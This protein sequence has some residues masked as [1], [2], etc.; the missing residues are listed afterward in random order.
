MD[1]AVL[2][3]YGW[4]DLAKTATCDFLLDYEETKRTRTKRS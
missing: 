3:A 4:H 1:R 2:E